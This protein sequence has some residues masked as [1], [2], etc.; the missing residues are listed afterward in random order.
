M[1]LPMRRPVLTTALRLT[2]GQCAICPLSDGFFSVCQGFM[3]AG[4]GRA[5]IACSMTEG[6]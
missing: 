5:A 2:V 4:D 1:S 6:D 3:F